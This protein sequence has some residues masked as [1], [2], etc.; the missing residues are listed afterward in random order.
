MTVSHPPSRAGP[1]WGLCSR[2]QAAPRYPCLSVRVSSPPPQPGWDS[3]PSIKGQF[4]R[5]R[6]RASPRTGL[7][8][9]RRDAAGRPGYRPAATDP[10]PPH[11]CPAAPRTTTAAPRRLP[12]PAEA[13]LPHLPRPPRRRLPAGGPECGPGPGG[14]RYRLHAAPAPP[15]GVIPGQRQL[16]P[17]PPRCRPARRLPGTGGD[18]AAPRTR[19]L[20]GLVVQGP[21]RRP[22]AIVDAGGR[23]RRRAAILGQGG[24]LTEGG[25]RE[26]IKSWWWAA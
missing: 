2:G 19:C 7:L 22:A 9:L 15:E 21:G 14:P 5:R 20:L 18:R 12:A 8:G 4:H 17:P 16:R 11:G 25:R 10:Q 6:G 3:G 26:R 13:R 23:R 1:S 24:L